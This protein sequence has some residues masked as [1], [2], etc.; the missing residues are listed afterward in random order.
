MQ[1]F[2]S[3]HSLSISVKESLVLRRGGAKGCRKRRRGD[4]EKP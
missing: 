3:T 4:E 1:S 2:K